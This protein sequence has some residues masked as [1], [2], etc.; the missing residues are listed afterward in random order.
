MPALEMPS[1][2]LVDF[3]IELHASHQNGETDKGF[4]M[5]FG[6]KDIDNAYIFTIAANG[7]YEIGKFKNGDW[8]SIYKGD[9][10]VIHKNDYSTNT[11]VL[12]Q[13]K[14]KWNFYINHKLIHVFYS[15]ILPGNKV[16]CFVEGKQKIGFDHLSYDEIEYRE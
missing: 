13:T 11:L 3:R 4:G 8:T 7:T 5:C 14:G 2:S 6:K 1:S 9:A 16:G 12:E 15:A 10:D